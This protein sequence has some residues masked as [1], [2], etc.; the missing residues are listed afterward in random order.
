MLFLSRLVQE[1]TLLDQRRDETVRVSDDY[2]TL[3]Q[4]L[5]EFLADEGFAELDSSKV[6]TSQ[7][8][9]L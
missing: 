7:L 8:L 2:S 5:D 1:L 9:V 3:S 6:I 4:T